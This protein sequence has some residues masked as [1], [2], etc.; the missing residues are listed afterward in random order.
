MDKI[1]EIVEAIQGLTLIE[2]FELKKALE[3][4]FG[5]TASTPVFLGNSGNSI[6]GSNAGDPSSQSEEGQKTEFDVVLTSVPADKKIAIIR[7]V[8]DKTGL[9]LKEAKDLVE[10]LPAKIKEGVKKEDAEEIKK[11]IEAENGTVELK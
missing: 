11:L 5:V 4:K 2:A 9:G 8:K 1:K 7:I 6:P 10:T 3:E